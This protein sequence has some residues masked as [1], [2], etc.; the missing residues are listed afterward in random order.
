MIKIEGA[1]D[2][3]INNDG[4]IYKM[5]NRDVILLL[6]LNNNNNFRRLSMT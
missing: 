1:L 4:L 5:I 6:F 2:A 3:Y